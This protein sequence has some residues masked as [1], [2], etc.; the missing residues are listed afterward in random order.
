MWQVWGTRCLKVVQRSVIIFFT[1]KTGRFDIK[2]KNITD[3]SQKTL[4]IA[5]LQGKTSYHL[6]LRAYTGAGMGPER[7]MFVVTKENCELNVVTELPSILKCIGFLVIFVYIENPPF[8]NF[9]FCYTFKVGGGQACVERPEMTSYLFLPIIWTCC[10][11]H[12]WEI[13]GLGIYLKFRVL[14]ACWTYGQLV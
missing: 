3:I 12:T 5:D 9:T 13:K 8:L 14:N 2:V 11:L 7:S 6:V 4:R 1:W 10:L